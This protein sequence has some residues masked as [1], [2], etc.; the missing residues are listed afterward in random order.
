MP[1]SRGVL[2]VRVCTMTTACVYRIIVLAS[3]ASIARA[4]ESN[5]SRLGRDNNMSVRSIVVIA[6]AL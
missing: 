3:T 2:C 1:D 4:E 6:P 5:T